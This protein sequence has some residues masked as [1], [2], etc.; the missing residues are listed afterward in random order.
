MFEIDKKIKEFIKKERENLKPVVILNMIRP[1]IEQMLDYDLPKK[2]ILDY[3]NRELKTNLNYRTFMSFLKKMKN[4]KRKNNIVSVSKNIDRTEKT[5][6]NK[7]EG[8]LK[9]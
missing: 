6:S 7:L 5:D 8:F 9:L 3:I 2:Y 4:E 1:T